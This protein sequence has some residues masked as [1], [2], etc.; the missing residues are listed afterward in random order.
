MGR[1]VRPTAHLRATPHLIEQAVT[2]IGRAEAGERTRRLS[3]PVEDSP[4]FAG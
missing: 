1:A 3:A 2:P 4:S